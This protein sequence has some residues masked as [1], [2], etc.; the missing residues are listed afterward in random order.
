MEE[1]KEEYSFQWLEIGEDNPFNKRILDVRSLTWNVVATTK[2]KNVAESYNNL[3]NSNG[4]EYI[5]T[6]I[7]NGETVDTLLEYPHNGDALEGIVFK[8]DSMDCKWDIYIY[9]SIFYFTRSWLGELIYKAHAEVLSDKLI[10]H[11]IEF[12]QEIGAELA[13]SDIHFLLTTHAMGK[14]LPHQIPDYLDSDMNIALYS[15]RQFGN[16][17]CYACFE[18]ITDTIIT[19]RDN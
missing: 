5:D 8:S 17:G 19:L 14:V 1:K 10:I 4:K 6:D 3:R 11:K 12:P 16:K 15:F 13:K 7:D 18:D 9:N 2:D